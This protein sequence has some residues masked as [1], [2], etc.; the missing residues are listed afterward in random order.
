[1]PPNLSN[2][3][4]LPPVSV[5]ILT[6]NGEKYISPLLRSLEA[7]TYPRELV[8]IIVVD[9]ASTDNTETII[10][11]KHPGVHPIV[12][13]KNV[14]FA[15]GNNHGLLHA[16]HDL[17]V[18]LNQDTVCHSEMLN[19][20]VNIMIKN[21]HLAACNP[22]IIPSDP[23][24]SATVNLKSAPTLLHLCDLSPFGYGKNRI[25]PGRS[26]YNTKLLSGCAFVIRRQ[27]IRQLGYLFDDRLWMYAED[28]DLSLRMYLRGQKI[29][30]VCDAVIFH[31]HSRNMGFGKSRLLLGGQAIKNRLL[32]YY[33]N[34]NLLEFLVFFPLLF[35]GGIFKIYEFPLTA[36]KK[37]AYLLP[38]GVFSMA[39]MIIAVFQLPAFTAQKR[40]YMAKRRLPGF[41]ILK[42]L[43]TR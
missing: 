17:L 31:L 38:F 5:I 8:E 33:K 19:S 3:H 13:K 30:A 10:R 35:Y 26:M 14:G 21:K 28:T 41:P 25:L 34:M 37:A 24:N 29:G 43:L 20:L 16:R 42:L 6:F 11:Q 23:A 22:N 4:P 27:T 1:M 2:N 36:A 9:N 39:C 12:L 18:F 7:Q 32:V 40:K 15:A